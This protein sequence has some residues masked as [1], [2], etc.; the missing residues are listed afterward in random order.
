[1]LPTNKDLEEEISKG[2]FRED[3]SSAYVIPFFVPPIAAERKE[4]IPL[5]ARYF[6]RSWRQLMAASRR[7]I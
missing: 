3:F 2:N 6:L 7:E 5:F 1:L 4:D